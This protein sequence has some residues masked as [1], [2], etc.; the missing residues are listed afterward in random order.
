MRVAA[1]G[2]FDSEIERIG[3]V[4]AAMRDALGPTGE[5]LAETAQNLALPDEE[6]LAAEAERLTAER[7]ERQ[8]IELATARLVADLAAEIGIC[9]QEFDDREVPTRFETLI[10]YVSGAAKHRR[11]RARWR[12][13]A[14]LN[15][16]AELLRRADLLAGLV[17]QERDF[18]I[19]QRR[20]SESD[21]VTF[22]DHRPEITEKL[23][24]EDGVAK[25]GTD[26]VGRTEPAIQVFQDFVAG[27]NARMGTCNILLHKLIGDTENLLILY[28]VV[29]DAG[30]RGDAGLK[31]E[32]FPHLVPEV[33]RFANGMLT[34]HGLDRRRHRAD[35]AF[36]ERFPAEATGEVAKSGGGQGGFRLPTIAGFKLVRSR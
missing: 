1:P 27:L 14:P 10:G 34:L 31:P 33:E 23:R 2:N 11:Q 30:G 19:G 7:P 20:E 21:L 29:A 26:L 17:R 24:G 28:R 4:L 12:S 32:L 9:A 3:N 6:T 15:R 18:L 13:P 8:A 36:A 25:T 35:Q 5:L 22:I 16:L